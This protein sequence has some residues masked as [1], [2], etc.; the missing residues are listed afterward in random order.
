MEKKQFAQQAQKWLPMLFR[1]ALSILKHPA[2]AEDALQEALQK[3]WDKREK[4]YEGAFKPYITKILI[5]ECRNV[6][7]HRM[8]VFAVA[9]M[10]DASVPAYDMEVRDMLDRLP[11]KLRIPFLLRYM[12][13]FTDKEIAKMLGLTASTVRGRVDRARKKLRTLFSEEAIGE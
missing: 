5:N 11:E 6:Q 2:D 3:A 8:R 1:I 9:E 7:R 12:E 10:K 4:I 13:D